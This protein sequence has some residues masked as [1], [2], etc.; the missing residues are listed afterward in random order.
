MTDYTKASGNG[1]LLIKDLGSTVEFWVKPYY[2]D[3]WW[4]NLSFTVTANGSSTNYAVDF[5]GNSWVKVTSRTISSSQTVTFKLNT[6]TGTSSLGGPTTFSQ[7][8]D[9]GT[10]PPQPDAPT[11]SSIG[12]TSVNASF[13]NNG[14][15]GLAL[16]NWA[17][18]YSTGSTPGTTIYPGSDQSGTIS[19]LSPGTKYNFWSRVHN[20]KGWSAWSP[21]KSATTL[22][23]PY[24]PTSI[25]VDQI[26]QRSVRVAFTDPNNGGSSITS[27]SIAYNTSNTLTGATIISTDGNDTVSGLLPGRQYYFWVR[28][29][30]AIGSGDWSGA[31]GALLVA[32][33]F[34]A[35]ADGT[36]KRAVPWYND[37]G[38]WKLIRPWSKSAGVWSQTK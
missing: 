20:S 3:F 35:M 7:Y 15:G 6:A 8:I 5:S 28:A 33:A 1:T 10:A 30:N 26:T 27:R 21:A 9:R 16:D 31:V 23:K 32:G 24:A 38:T 18:A 19:G 37:A 13:T 11:I 17:I 34:V 25:V 36:T 29:N 22:R 2:S 12:S 4:Q 14:N